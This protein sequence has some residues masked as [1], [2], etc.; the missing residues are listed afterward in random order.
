MR[1][2]LFIHAACIF[3]SIS[4]REARFFLET[5]AKRN[6]DESMTQNE[7]CNQNNDILT[8]VSESGK[9]TLSSGADKKYKWPG[10]RGLL[11]SLGV[12]F[13]SIPMRRDAGRGRAQA[14]ESPPVGPSKNEERKIQARGRRHPWA[15]RKN[16][17]RRSVPQARTGMATGELTLATLVDTRPDELLLHPLTNSLDAFFRRWFLEDDERR[18]SS[19]S[20]SYA[21]AASFLPQNPTGATDVQ[22]LTTQKPSHTSVCRSM[23]SWPTRGMAVPGFSHSTPGISRGE[24]ARGSRSLRIQDGGEVWE[25]GMLSQ[26]RSPGACCLSWRRKRR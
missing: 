22:D 21:S 20:S 19:S 7:L 17:R 6:R 12:R 8:I 5:T 9:V 25:R 15:G 14:S 18:P 11:G 4:G 16:Y 24:A 2:E 26:E 13:L 1:F 10:A 23:M 3:D